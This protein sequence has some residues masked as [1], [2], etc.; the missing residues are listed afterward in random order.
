MALGGALQEGVVLGGALQEGVGLGGALQKGVGLERS[1]FLIWIWIQ[2]GCAKNKD[3]WGLPGTGE[4]NC[5]L[6]LYGHRLS[7]IPW[8]KRKA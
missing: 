2:I 8:T 6:S 4:G 5:Q 1:S 7:S 3:S